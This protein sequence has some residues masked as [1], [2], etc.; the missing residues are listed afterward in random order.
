MKLKDLSQNRLLFTDSS[1]KGEI[2]IDLPEMREFNKNFAC[3]HL[4]I[5]FKYSNE[6]EDAFIFFY[7]EI[8]NHTL[9]GLPKILNFENNSATPI[10]NCLKLFSY[11]NEAPSI[12][13]KREI[14]Y[15]KS[16][17]GFLTK[18]QKEILK[19]IIGLGNSSFLFNNSAYYVIGVGEKDGK[20]KSIQNVENH[21]T[22]F[23]QIVFLC[24]EYIRI[25]F[26]L[27]P[28]Q[29]KIYNLYEMIKKGEINLEI[30]FTE[31][32]K[33]SS[34]DDNI[35]IIQITR[36]PK[37]CLELKKEFRWKSDKGVKKFSKGKSW[38]R[39]GSHTFDLLIEEA[40]TL[41]LN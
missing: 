40:K 2:F 3:K 22:L 35:F 39:I 36:T 33:K 8:R 6:V 24:R 21:N 4:Q 27:I 30:P 9:S 37:A 5:F 12:D 28:I 7:E 19:D 38:I 15:K 17:K 29:I 25:G 23:Q 11:I 16:K 32:Q 1:K 31:S 18:I 34:C 10:E 26:N 20:F 13:F 14:N 41:L